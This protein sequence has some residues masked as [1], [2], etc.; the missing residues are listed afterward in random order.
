M[1]LTL[2]RPLYLFVL[3][4]CLVA[5]GKTEK[6]ILLPLYVDA[7]EDMVG[8]VSLRAN[9]YGGVVMST[10]R[11]GQNIVISMRGGTRIPGADG[12][13]LCIKG[14]IKRGKNALTVNDDDPL[15]VHKTPEGWV[16]LSGSGTFSGE[17]EWT[18]GEGRTVES[19]LDA[20]RSPDYLLRKGCIID[21]QRLSTPDTKSGVLMALVDQLNDE[22]PEV[23]QAAAESIGLLGCHSSF[24]ALRSAHVAETEEIAQIYM[25][26]ALSLCSGVALLNQSSEYEI[27]PEDLLLL[28]A[29]YSTEW[30]DKHMLSAR[31]FQREE[32]AS[33][34]RSYLTHKQASVRYAA[35]QFLFAVTLQNKKDEPTKGGALEYAAYTGQ[36]EIV[37]ELLNRGPLEPTSKTSVSPFYY[38]AHGGHAEIIDLLASH[39]TGLGAYHG[40][41]LWSLNVAAR[42]G[43]LDVVRSLISNGAYPSAGASRSESNYLIARKHGHE[44][45]AEL[46]ILSGSRLEDE[47]KKDTVVFE[48]LIATNPTVDELLGKIEDIMLLRINRNILLIPDAYAYDDWYNVRVKKKLATPGSS[49]PE[50]WKKGFD[51]LLQ[52]DD[53]RSD[54][55]YEWEAAIL[56]YIKGIREQ[57]GDAITLN[58]FDS[59]IGALFYGRYDELGCAL[60]TH[61]TTEWSG[62][63]DERMQAVMSYRM[64]YCAK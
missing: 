34:M 59:M 16:Y 21:L 12:S 30:S 26:E 33:S 4:L 58:L 18:V 49:D 41:E 37:R 51:Y 7:N 38:A 46:L 47:R 42:K 1:L 19:C 57:P 2:T 35:G 10:D 9:I 8:R 56:L 23:R 28:Y 63:L 32:V 48:K 22:I 13:E 44:E 52:G 50:S 53:K 20:L 55:P 60:V 61:I 14:V 25:G 45:I 54:Y 40:P 29:E 17:N 27:P 31:N 64:P 6:R 11:P 39:D 15:C 24:Q 43:Y 5:C 36:L 62:R 3:V